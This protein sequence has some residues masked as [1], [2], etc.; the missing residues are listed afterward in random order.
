MDV[1]VQLENGREHT[2]TYYRLTDCLPLVEVGV[3]DLTLS[4]GM[5][6]DYHLPSD[7]WQKQDYDNMATL[8]RAAAWGVY[9]HADSLDAPQWN[10]QN[11][12]TERY[13]RACEDAAGGSG[14][15]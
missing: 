10:G 7:E 4:I 12:Q 6:P 5:A 14:I 3:S 2:A 1:G 13:G 8:A 11:P 15:K 9:Q